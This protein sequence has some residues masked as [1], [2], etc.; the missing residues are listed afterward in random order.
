MKCLST[1]SLI[2]EPPFTSGAEYD[3]ESSQVHSVSQRRVL[4]PL[5]P[6]SPPL[7]QILLTEL[8]RQRPKS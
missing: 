7:I 3:K 5:L 4:S 1:S 2:K 8:W 6:K